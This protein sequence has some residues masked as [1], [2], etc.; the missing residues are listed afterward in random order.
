MIRAAVVGLG[1][2]MAHVAG[3]L[4]SEEA[5]L[6]AVCDLMA[7]RGER[8][9][10]TFDSGSMLCLKPLFE[11]SLLG[12][13]WQE[14]GVKVFTSFERLLEDPLVDVVSI[15]TPDYLHPE[16]LEMAMDSGKHILLE[17]PV[18]ITFEEA[19]KLTARVEAYH[20]KI[21]IG[22]EFR[23]NPAVTQMRR[24][25][26]AGEIGDVEA[27]SLYHF[28]TPFRKDKWNQWIQ[29]REFSGGLVVEETCHWFDLASYI[30][31]KSI[32]ELSCLTTPAIL[33]DF[34]FED[35]AYIQGRFSQGG[36]FQI[37]HALTGFDF[38][39]Q[40]TVHGTKGTLW[41][42]LKEE[43]SSLL[44]AGLTDHWGILCKGAP[45]APR[46]EVTTWVYGSEVSEAENIRDYV[47]AFC[48]QIVN[49]QEPLATFDDGLVSLKAS[50]KALEAAK[51]A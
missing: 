39:L 40:L 45:N 4:E 33:E 41:C 23:I 11:K 43:S 22:Y 3:Y 14:I 18:G 29:K 16:H 20:K 42:N 21:S 50:L 10:G 7:T 44:D 32:G 13:R 5:E 1:I 15:C 30:T 48:S 9:G 26:Q 31:G 8:V 46:E 38:S 25:I 2:G 51:N 19:E 35:V 28:R 49:D 34:D 12:R 27:F 24:L 17:K 36:I 37:S 6:Y 47:K